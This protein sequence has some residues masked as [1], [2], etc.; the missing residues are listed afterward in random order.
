MAHEK[1]AL[2]GDAEPDRQRDEE[3]RG[4]RDDPEGGRSTI[5]RPR[6]DHR[7]DD[8]GKEREGRRDED[9]PEGRERTG[10]AHEE[11][12]L[13]N[14]SSERAAA[15]DQDRGRVHEGHDVRERQ[16][17]DRDDASEADERCVPWEHARPVDHRE[18]GTEDERRERDDRS[19]EHA[20]REEDPR[21]LG[22]REAPRAQLDA[23]G[24]ER[25]REELAD[26]PRG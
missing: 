4:A 6:S 18:I 26:E 14:G 7:R 19:E 21:R 10:A 22:P 25:K 3:Q 12:A 20:A 13:E 8:R 1:V 9:E 11:H 17:R 24:T 5:E 16:E 15:L 2:H 23:G